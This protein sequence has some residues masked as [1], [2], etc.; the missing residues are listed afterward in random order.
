VT[1]VPQQALF[2]MNSPFVHSQARRLA[3]LPEL[4]TGATD[5][6]IRRL[7]RLL[8]ARDPEAH[9]LALGVDFLRRHDD[10]GTGK[11][12]LTPWEEYAQVLLLTNEFVFVD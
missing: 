10:G 1:T 12:G 6:R 5:D 7:Y 2:L 9:E 3:A 4:T 8:F 11:A